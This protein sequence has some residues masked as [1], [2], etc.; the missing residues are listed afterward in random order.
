MA[1]SEK[2]SVRDIIVGVVL[3]VIFV[4]AM[5]VVRGIYRTEGEKRSAEISNEGEKDANHISANVKLLSI[6][7]VKGDIQARIEF[8]PE[9]NL[10]K[11]DG[12]LARDLKLF[13][14][15]ANGKQDI[16]FAKG[17]RMNSVDTTI[18]LYDGLATDYPFDTHSAYL[19]LYLTTAPEKKPD[20]A[21]P[22]P[23]AEP[24]ATPAATPA[25]A[26]A[27]GS[28]PATEPKP[29]P[30]A[31]PEEEDD[32]QVALAVDFFG[33]V[34]GYKIEATKAKES[35]DDYVGIDLKVSRS[36]TVKFF[37]EFVM[38]LMWGATIAV[39]FLVLSV[40]L[41]GRKIEVGM[42]SFLAALI[43]ALIAV[44]N[45]Q[46]GI[47]PIGTL[48]DFVAFFWAEVILSLCLLS[49][50]FVWLFRPAGK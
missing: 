32:N 19:E 17:K 31:K 12:T 3:I 30:A 33:S 40:V 50:L 41:G 45:A 28:A 11:P 38:F 39:L 1:I 27:D 46:P 25:A 16:E 47:P 18:S 15:S 36:S 10:A 26:P 14:N 6:D 49:I 13:V 29:E 43:F 9:G 5:F 44:R 7:P 24:A 20:A 23:G 35:D 2:V 22:A 42:F 48:S 34:P 37:S 21:K 4:V 8:T